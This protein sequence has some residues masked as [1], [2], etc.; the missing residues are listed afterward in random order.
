MPSASLS[1]RLAEFSQARDGGTDDD[2]N[3]HRQREHQEA[4]PQRRR[5]TFRL[6]AGE[7]LEL[8]AFELLAH[9]C[10]DLSAPP[11]AH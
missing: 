9:P 5:T 6:Q 3:E 2:G 10:R 11:A 4:A 8:T 7:L 1:V